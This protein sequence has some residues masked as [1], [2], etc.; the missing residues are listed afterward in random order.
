M[1][2]RNLVPL[3]VAVVSCCKSRRGARLRN[4]QRELVGELAR[5]RGNRTAQRRFSLPLR[6]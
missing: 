2:V 4:V 1:R 5:E 6:M 3:L